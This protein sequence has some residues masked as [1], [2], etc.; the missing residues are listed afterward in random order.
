MVSSLGGGKD[1]DG[2]ASNMNS[3]KDVAGAEPYESPIESGSGR[4]SIPEGGFD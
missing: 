3:S 2:L 4:V 1:W